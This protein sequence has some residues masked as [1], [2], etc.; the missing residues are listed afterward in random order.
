MR[1]NLPLA[2]SRLPSVLAKRRLKI[3]ELQKKL[4]AAGVKINQKSLYRLTSA[5]PLQR[6]D[7]RILAAI[8]QTCAVGI[9]EVIS[10]EAPGSVLL[11]LDKAEQKRL[12]EFMSKHREGKLTPDETR[13]F[14]LLSEKAHDL[15]MTNAR[16]LV[17][18]RRALNAPAAATLVPAGA[19]QRRAGPKRA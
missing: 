1:S 12:D 6:L 2:Y 5:A 7:T 18:Q 9:Q 13:E 11:K 10:F 17:A 19:R 15:T 4:Q 8:C 14:D 16:M 3:S